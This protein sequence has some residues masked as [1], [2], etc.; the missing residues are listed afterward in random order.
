LRATAL[1]GTALRPAAGGRAVVVIIAVV[2]VTIV[3]VLVAVAA[4]PI[5]DA[6]VFVARRALFADGEVTAVQDD[7]DRSERCDQRNEVKPIHGKPSFSRSRLRALGRRRSRRERSKEN[8][9]LVFERAQR[10]WVLGRMKL[11]DALSSPR[12]RRFA[13]LILAGTLAVGALS[14]HAARH[15]LYVPLPTVDAEALLPVGEAGGA[16]GP[17]STFAFPASERMRF[18]GHVVERLEAGNYVYLAIE[19]PSG[20]RVWV[21]TLGSSTGASRS[22]TTASVVAVGYA[23]HFA[24]KRLGRTFD[25]LYFAVVRPV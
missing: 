14:A 11:F 13:P 4:R 2:S 7:G 16:Q 8:F 1:P 24:S 22:V 18:E 23:P 12:A 21:V 10:R 6:E 5:L 3:I 19:R 15:W 25:G 20:E 17:L 9:L